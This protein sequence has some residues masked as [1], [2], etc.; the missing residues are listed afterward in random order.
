MHRLFVQGALKRQRNFNLPATPD[1]QEMVPPG[2]I[3]A[4]ALVQQLCC[5]ILCQSP[6]PRPFAK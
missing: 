1:L 5:K 6:S 2:K 4:A 3:H